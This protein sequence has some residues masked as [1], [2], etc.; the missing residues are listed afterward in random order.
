M[1]WIGRPNSFSSC[2]VDRLY[3]DVDVRLVLVFVRVACQTARNIYIY[4]L[5]II[6]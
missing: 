4:I 5:Y 2:C 3:I 6:I 1:L